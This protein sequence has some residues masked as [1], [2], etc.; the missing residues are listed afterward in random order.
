MVILQTMDWFLENPN[1]GYYYNQHSP[2]LVYT[3]RKSPSLNWSY[4]N[5]TRWKANKVAPVTYSHEI[6]IVWEIW[7]YVLYLTYCPVFSHAEF[8]K[9]WG[10]A[11][12]LYKETTRIFL[13]S[14][15]FVEIA[16][17]FYTAFRLKVKM[18]FWIVVQS[19]NR[20]LADFFI[21]CL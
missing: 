6:W 2:R 18:L 17:L 8:N 20:K 15:H 14:Y 13:K 1:H 4:N 3:C 10:W 19:L 11:K 7:Q 5:T 9:F 12:L 21:S 16:Q